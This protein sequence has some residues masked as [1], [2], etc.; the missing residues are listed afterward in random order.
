M[1][2]KLFGLIGFSI[3]APSFVIFL[4][5]NGFPI[6][7]GLVD[8]V[9]SASGMFLIFEGIYKIHQQP[10]KNRFRRLLRISIGTALLTFHVFL[11]LK[12]NSI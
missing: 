4:K 5:I 12:W 10:H 6:V 11:L 9:A 7:T 8:F 1:N 2:N 3:A